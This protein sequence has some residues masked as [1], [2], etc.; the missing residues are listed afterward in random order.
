MRV[1]KIV[2]VFLFIMLFVA[3]TYNSQDS[4]MRQEQYD[5]EQVKIELQQFREK[6]LDDIPF[7]TSGFSISRNCAFVRLYNSQVLATQA[8]KKC[9]CG[10]VKV[11]FAYTIKLVLEDMS[12]TVKDI[13]ESKIIMNVRRTCVRSITF[14]LKGKEM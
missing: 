4:M 11:D 7:I 1:L 9:E 13:S 14:Y 12:I 8:K 10:L 5:E 2:M 3:V 6:Q